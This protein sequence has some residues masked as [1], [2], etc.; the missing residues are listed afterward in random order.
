MADP[1]IDCNICCRLGM[2]QTPRYLK[3]YN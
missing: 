3:T 2:K 1:E